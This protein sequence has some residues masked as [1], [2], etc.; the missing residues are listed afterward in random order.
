MLV[1]GLNHRTTPLA[2]RERVAVP[3]RE[4]P[5][6]L[7]ALYRRGDLDEVALL[8]TCNRTEVYVA[9][10][11]ASA[12]IPVLTLWLAARGGLSLEGMRDYVYALSD[13]EAVAQLFRVA[14][15]LDS[16]ILGESEIAAQVKQAYEAA[17]AAGTA[18]VLLHRLFQKA[19]HSAKL[20]R[21]R[22]RLADGRASIGSVVAALANERFGERLAGCE[23]LLW[24]AGKAAEA[25]ARHLIKSGIRQLW[26]VSRTQTKAQ[27]LASLCQS[28]WLA[29][30]QALKHVAH[31]DIAIVCTQ[32][33][34]Y[35]IDGND[36]SR[37]HA[38]RGPQPLLLV[39]LSVPRNVDPAL[40]RFSNVALYNI[41]DLQAFTQAAR[42]QRLEERSRGEA[43][44][45]QQ[46]DH[47]FWRKTPINHEETQACSAVEACCP[48]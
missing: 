42:S 5:E 28:G 48:A 25:T 17:Q 37:L 1:V 31:V 36:F 4:L 23:V 22:T 38:Q 32:A 44:I 29:W 35:V 9:A 21:S 20:V 6:I 15:G 46:V 3:L 19:L 2:V 12:Q 34:H 14:A 30:E 16:M 40:S 27:D 43:L 8:S 33:P 10:P 39:D 47:F 24:G 41:D 45:G 26:I 13:D 11:D 18:S 7:P